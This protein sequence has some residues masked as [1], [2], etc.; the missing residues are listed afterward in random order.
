MDL[1]TQPQS[2]F[3]TPDAKI[4]NNPD[5]PVLVHK[6]I[7]DRQTADKEKV[8]RRHFEQNG[9]RGN[10]T[11]FVFDYHH[12]H[13][14]S[15]ECLAIGKGHITLMIGGENGKEFDLEAGDMIV[16]PAGTGHR[17]I[18]SSENLIVVGVY[19]EGQENYD[20]CRS[21]SQCPGAEE[22]IAN[23]ARPATDPFYGTRGPLLKEWKL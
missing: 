5:L 18:S 2:I 14:T 12:F 21:L 7:L 17:M 23:L 9:W 11:G 4:P 16:L 10:W 6:G 20:I 8:F 13:T 3:F 19:P 1:I 15:H 22:K